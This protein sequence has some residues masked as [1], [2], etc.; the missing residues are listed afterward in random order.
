M[1]Y[2]SFF[3]RAVAFLFEGAIQWFLPLSVL[4]FGA[5]NVVNL[6]DLTGLL[7]TVFTISVWAWPL[8]VLYLS[9]LTSSVGGGGKGVTEGR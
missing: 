1:K 8:Y 6:A 3:Q 2:A 4:S 9:F 7:I 5:S